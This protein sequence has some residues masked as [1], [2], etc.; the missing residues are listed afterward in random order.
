MKLQFPELSN[1]IRGEES[2]IFRNKLGET[3]CVEVKATQ[4][5][6]SALLEKVLN[7]DKQ[8]AELLALEVHKDIEIDTIRT[9]APR[10]DFDIDLSNLGVW[11]DPIGWCVS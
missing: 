3:I 7:G 1:S 11:I 4:D 6:T 9:V 10:G 2:N 5:Q 8:A